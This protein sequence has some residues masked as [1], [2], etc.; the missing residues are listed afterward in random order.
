MTLSDRLRY[1]SLRGAHDI[2]FNM[3][4]HVVTQSN[5][6][7]PEQ[8][9]MFTPP[10]KEVMD[11]LGKDLVG[12][13]ESVPDTKWIGGCIPRSELFNRLKVTG[14]RY[15]NGHLGE[16]FKQTGHGAE[17]SDLFNVA[18]ISRPSALRGL[19]QINGF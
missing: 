14:I 5:E 10:S 19:V 13:W 15:N 4:D 18:A 11:K 3:S 12:H 8:V 2:H 1:S 16:L 7:Q 17:G 9:M 6:A